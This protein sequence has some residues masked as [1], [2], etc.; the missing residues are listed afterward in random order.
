MSPVPI[1]RTE[2]SQL[3]PPSVSSRSPKLAHRP[4]HT[5]EKTSAY[6]GRCRLR[7]RIASCKAN[8]TKLPK[9]VGYRYDMIPIFRV[10]ILRDISREENE[11]RTGLNSGDT[12][13]KACSLVWQRIKE[14]THRKIGRLS[15]ARPVSCSYP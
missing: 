12:C 7:Y 4:L 9:A 6:C 10:M 1:P 14:Q 2:S 8:R 13:K 3:I 5:K 11:N 15:K